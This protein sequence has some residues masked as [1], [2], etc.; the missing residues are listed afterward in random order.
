MVRCATESVVADDFPYH[1]LVILI[2]VLILVS[3]CHRYCHVAVI[4][5]IV[6]PAPSGLIV[7]LGRHQCHQCHCWACPP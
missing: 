4:N 7:H 1:I 2:L 6:G 3:Y 5:V